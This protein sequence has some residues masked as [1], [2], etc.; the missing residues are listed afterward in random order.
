MKLT[1]SQLKRQ[2]SADLLNAAS[3]STRKSPASNT[4]NGE[5]TPPHNLDP[6]IAPV[7]LPSASIFELEAPRAFDEANIGS[8]L[9]KQRASVTGLDDEAIKR[10]LGLGL[11][12][13]TGDLL[14]QIDSVQVN[15]GPDFVEQGTKTGYDYD[16][17]QTQK[18]PT[19]DYDEQMRQKNL[20][21]DYNEQMTQKNPGSDDEEL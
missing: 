19:S 20:A 12:G 8:P 2:H 7:T 11:A 9:K 16:E 6:S 17:Q 5:S 21:S 13:L 15:E 3:P 14:A 10:R 4:P 18:N 1:F